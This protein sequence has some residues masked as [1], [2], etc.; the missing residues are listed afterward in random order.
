MGKLLLLKPA[1]AA[2]AALI[3][4]AGALDLKIAAFAATGIERRRKQLGEEFASWY[5]DKPPDE[6]FIERGRGFE[7]RVSARRNVTAIDIRGAYKKLGLARFLKSASLT[8][9]AL[10]EF[11]SQPEIDALS[12]TART[13]SRSFVTTPIGAPAVEMPAPAIRDAA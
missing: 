12:S 2:R 13:G 3:S 4:E 5:L 8:L 1:A 10:A 6:E 7:L 9:K 11:L